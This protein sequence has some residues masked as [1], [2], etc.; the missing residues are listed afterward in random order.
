MRIDNPDGQEGPVLLS[1]GALSNL[2]ALRGRC[3][4]PVRGKVTG[5]RC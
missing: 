5:G 1:D 3:T 4:P 2:H